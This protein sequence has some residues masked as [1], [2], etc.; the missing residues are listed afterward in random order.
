MARADAFA[1]ITRGLSAKDHMDVFLDMCYTFQFI[2][3]YS[4]FIKFNILQNNLYRTSISICISFYSM[5]KEK[6]KDR[7]LGLGLLIRT[8]QKGHFQFPVTAQTYC[9]QN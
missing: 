8:A 6:K 2:Y 5:N 3:F 4:I 9:A 7:P 1:D